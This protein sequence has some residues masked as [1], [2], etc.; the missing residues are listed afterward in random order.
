MTQPVDQFLVSPVLGLPD[1]RGD[2]VSRAVQRHGVGQGHDGQHHRNQ[3]QDA[4][5]RIPEHGIASSMKRGR[6][7]GADALAPEPYSVLM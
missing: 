2:R 1:Q 3:H 7:H 6:P 4:P 5:N